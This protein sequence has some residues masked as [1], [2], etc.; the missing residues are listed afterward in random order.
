M[1]TYNGS[2]YI[3]E[4]I[5]SIRAQSYPDWTLY[6]RDDGSRDD[7]VQKIEQIERT[8]NRVRLMRDKLGNQGA[9]GNFSILM[10]TAVEENAGYLFFADQDDVWYPE[11]L[12]V[13][14]DAL[15]QLELKQ[16]T[17]TPLLV[18][19]D[20][21]LVDEALRPIADSFVT[22][23]GLSPA[24]LNLGVL[25]CENQV[26]GCASAINRSLLELATPIPR[27]ALM[28]DWWL[29]LLASSTGKIEFISRPLAMYRQHAGNVL[30]ATSY[31]QRIG[32][33]L[34]SLRQ[35]KVQMTRI[36]DS[37]MQAAVL[38][39]RVRTRGM[40]L[41]LST[42]QKIDAYANILNVRRL[43]RIGTL[44]AQSIGR[45]ALGARWAHNLLIGAMA[46]KQ[47]AR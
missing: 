31:W 15:R 29:A 23:S 41:P 39:Q 43:N 13:M 7:T 18:H 3:D 22:Y 21:L 47:E 24:K 1:A 25:L 38:E 16:G 17:E 10:Q 33:F 9:A 20:L 45:S 34:F 11:K 19:S 44:R 40:K 42:Q 37:L 12:A 27:E 14:L 36:R 8:D 6:V 46:R 30:G 28:H 35:W 32:R 26:T 5:E 2:R 4:Q